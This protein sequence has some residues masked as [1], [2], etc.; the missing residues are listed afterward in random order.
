MSAAYVIYIEVY[1]TAFGRR[2][3]VEG[4]VCLEG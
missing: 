1:D 3:S 4:D 2:D